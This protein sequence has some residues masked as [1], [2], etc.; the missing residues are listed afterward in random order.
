MNKSKVNKIDFIGDIHGHADK[1]QELLTKLGYS[2]INGVYSH[3]QRKALFVGDYIDRG[4]QILASCGV[5]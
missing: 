3:H 4:P 5:N 1:L 2:Y